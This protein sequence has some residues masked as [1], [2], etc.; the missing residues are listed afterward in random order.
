MTEP[1]F[2]L[3]AL[4]R[5]QSYSWRGLLLLLALSMAPRIFGYP[6]SYRLAW[7]GLALI[8]AATIAKVIVMAEQFRHAR[9][10]RYSLLSYTLL[11]ILAG[12]VIV[13]LLF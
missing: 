11:F 2:A 3:K 8:L 4:I 7:G 1:Y 5:L 9:L 6:A 10:Y 13:R 12:V